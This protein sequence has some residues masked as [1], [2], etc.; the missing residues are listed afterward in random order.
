M[1]TFDYLLAL[2]SVN[3]SIEAIESSTTHQVT[4]ALL[5]DS[6]ALDLVIDVKK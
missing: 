6:E 4:N 5:F 3:D 2:I 1:F